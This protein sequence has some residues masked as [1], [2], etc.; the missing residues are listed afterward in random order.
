MLSYETSKEKF[1]E[2][3]NSNLWGSVESRSGEGSEI[4]YTEPL[5]KWL[6]EKINSLDIKTVVDAAC[7]DFNWMKL[8]LREVE[9]NYIGLDIVEEV[10]EGNNLAYGSDR[11]EF[12]VANIC[13]D[14]LQDCDLI[15]V[16]DC[17]FHLSYDDINS[18]LLNL[19]KTN[20]KYLLTTT[21]IV[22]LEFKNSDISTG[23]HRL[24]DLFKDPFNFDVDHVKDRVADFPEGYQTK[25]EMIIVEKKF[26]P[27]HLA[28]VALN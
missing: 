3:Y 22:D 18:F 17:L 8:V 20:Y 24:I 10:I 26:V 15:I 16:R 2:I 12:G 21:H 23:Y 27:I 9:V 6:I 1:S 7:G 4:G 5:R 11:I 14:K 13:E 25:R 19:S 28:K